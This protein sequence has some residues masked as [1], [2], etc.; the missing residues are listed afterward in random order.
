VAVVGK[1]PKHKRRFDRYTTFTTAKS[2]RLGQRVRYIH[3]FWIA[4]VEHFYPETATVIALHPRTKEVTIQVYS[5]FRTVK[6]T[7][8]QVPT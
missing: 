2:V 7:D 1:V 4:G 5:Y 6:V 3:R 8:L